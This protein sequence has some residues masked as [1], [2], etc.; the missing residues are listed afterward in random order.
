M[1]SERIFKR[2]QPQTPFEEEPFTRG[3][4][5]AVGPAG[6]RWNR[7]SRRWGPAE[8]PAGTNC[9]L[10]GTLHSWIL[11]MC[12]TLLVATAPSLW[13]VLILNSSREEDFLGPLGNIDGT[14]SPK[15]CAPFSPTC[16]THPKF[17]HGF[18]KLKQQ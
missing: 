6:R 14:N 9:T 15:T 5:A 1:V 11:T 17:R 4:E 18:L 8:E 2:F 12:S 10:C 7:R 13:R 16:E 3:Q